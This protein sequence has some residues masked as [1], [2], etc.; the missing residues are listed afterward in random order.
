MMFEQALFLTMV[1]KADEY[2]EP[3]RQKYQDAVLRFGIP[4]WDPFL[5]RQKLLNVH[6]YSFYRTGLPIILT[7]KKVRVRT[8]K[9]PEVLVEIDNPLYRFDFPKGTNNWDGSA[10][11]HWVDKDN[12]VSCYHFLLQ[13]RLVDYL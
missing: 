5:P 2:P 13:Y 4:Y 9:S 1:A 10:P 3:Y 11:F 7:V 8:P 12:P 6:G